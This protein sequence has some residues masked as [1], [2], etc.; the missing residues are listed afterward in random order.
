MKSELNCK[1]CK[2]MPTFYTHRHTV[3]ARVPVLA[4]V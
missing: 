3:A 4:L 2:L 1:L